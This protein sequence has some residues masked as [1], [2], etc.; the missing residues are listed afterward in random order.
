[1][2]TI[3][4]LASLSLCIFLTAG[5]A[6]AQ[7]PDANAK[8]TES[9]AAPA[10]KEKEIG[11][12][13]HDG[14]SLSGT[15]VLITRNGNVEKL[16]KE[17]TL[18]SGLRVEPDGTLILND[19]SKMGLRPTQLLTFD[20]KLHN[21]QAQSAAALDTGVVTDSSAAARTPS[22]SALTKEAQDAAS[23]EAERRARA[24]A[25]AQSARPAPEK[26]Q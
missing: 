19:G 9:A 7:A 21:S 17:F 23:A 22:N 14:I 20:G 10:S 2:D 5:H 6:V 11:I 16:A 3:R 24:A 4:N 8:A 1:M 13:A 15:D 25:D 26:T 12:S 18:E